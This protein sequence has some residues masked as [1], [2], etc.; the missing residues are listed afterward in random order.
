MISIET[1][2][3]A[4][5]DFLDNLAKDVLLV[6][7][8]NDVVIDTKELS[9]LMDS[10]KKYINRR[11]TGINNLEEQDKEIDLKNKSLKYSLLL[12]SG[13]ENEFKTC[14][15]IMKKVQENKYNTLSELVRPKLIAISES[16]KELE[17]A[18]QEMMSKYHVTFSE[19]KP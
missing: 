1:T 4:Q 3:K 10:A 7:D 11:I 2:K 9:Q 15:E 14:L 6:K 13:Y 5:Q 8:N 19:G 12:K 17:N 16:K 18:I